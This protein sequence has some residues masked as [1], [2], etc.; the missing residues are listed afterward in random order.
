MTSRRAILLGHLLVS[1]PILIILVLAYLISRRGLA[2]TSVIALPSAFVIAW[3]YWSL[4]A[5]RWRLWALANVI[6]V[7][8]SDL[9]ARAAST[10]LLWRDGSWLQRTELRPK[11]Y[12]ESRTLAQLLG[13]LRRLRLDV[14]EAEQDDWGANAFEELLR[15]IDPVIRNLEQGNLGED[16]LTRLG[17]LAAQLQ[18]ASEAGITAMSGNLEESAARA[19][20]D[21]VRVRDLLMLRGSLH[22]AT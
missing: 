5:P 6:D 21:L 3:L 11:N 8:A 22:V 10:G 2:P 15:H 7:P 4:M 18:A 12:L 19:Q 13:T 1:L 16:S 17:A 20:D 14:M 9:L